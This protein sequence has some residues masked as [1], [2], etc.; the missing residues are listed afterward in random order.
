[1]AKKPG[2]TPNAPT[3]REKLK[4]FVEQ[5]SR[6][7]IE[8]K[9]LAED[10]KEIYAEAK[11][12]G[13]DPKALRQVVKDSLKT[14]TERAAARETEALVDIYRANLG[15]LD[16]TPLGEAARRKYEE[17]IRAAED[18]AKREDEG[19]E[20]AGAS[21]DAPLA[22]EAPKEPTEDDARDMGRADH[23]AGKRIFD[24]PFLAGTRNRA[25]WDS[26][27]CL[28]DGSDGMEIPRQWRRGGNEKRE[29]VA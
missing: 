29:G 23:A 15:L 7:E 26:G 25:A 11:N 16:G 19:G 27:F 12:D 21:D 13:F 20:S 5:V 10:I 24:N 28:E 22:P 8:R 2:Q 9:S 3:S 18:E 17:D 6:L 1:M 4:A 14:Q